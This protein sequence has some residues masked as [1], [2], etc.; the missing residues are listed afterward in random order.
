MGIEFSGG[1]LWVNNSVLLAD[2]LHGTTEIELSPN[3]VVPMHL[4]LYKHKE[5]N[6]SCEV[7]CMNLE[8]LN[9]HSEKPMH[10]IPFSLMYEADIML[11]ARWHKKARIRKKWLKRYGMKPDKV[12]FV[13]KSCALEYNTND[14]HFE[15]DAMDREC[16]LRPD[17]KRRGLKIELQS[18]CYEVAE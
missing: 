13:Y 9:K 12:R 7:D 16:R 6:F 14:N 8:L 18:Q 5:A 4:N 11:Q 3:E 17:Q 10:N 1:S 15:L 2:E